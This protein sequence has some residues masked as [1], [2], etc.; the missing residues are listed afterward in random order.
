[1]AVLMLTGCMAWADAC[2]QLS[3]AAGGGG[4]PLAA[5]GG[6]TVTRIIHVVAFDHITMQLGAATAALLLAPAGA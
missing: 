3:Y 5:A 1:M 6:L 2:E 4:R